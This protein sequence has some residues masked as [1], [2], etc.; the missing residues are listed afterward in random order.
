[1]GLWCLNKHSHPLM[2]KAI[3]QVWREVV[4][5]RIWPVMRVPMFI[6][7]RTNA[8]SH[9]LWRHCNEFFCLIL[10]FLFSYHV[11]I[12]FSDE[13]NAA[14]LMMINQWTRLR[15]GA[16]RKQAIT[17]AYVD[18]DICR[19]LAMIII[20]MFYRIF[21]QRYSKWPQC[22][23]MCFSERI[24]IAT[25]DL[26]FTEFGSQNSNRQC[27]SIDSRYGL[28]PKR[29]RVII[30][31]NVY[32]VLWYHYASHSLMWG[33]S[34]L[35]CDTIWR[36]WTGSLLHD[37]V[38]KW[39]NFP[40]YWPFVRGIYRSLV[41]SLHKGQWRGALMF[42]L[43]CVWIKGWLNNRE[44]GDLRRHRAHYDVILMVQVMSCRLLGTIKAII[45][46]N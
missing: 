29:H 37:D 30:W 32:I 44:A 12:M 19:H 10:W 22:T 35:P 36:R 42:S 3:G 45:W 13:Y 7:L 9:P 18:P 34:S 21:S 38:I 41:N 28:A 17:W 33:N 24:Y 26:N 5:C 4:G 2:S 1:M 46:T 43:I 8:L 25:L 14:L 27:I 15:L 39:K 11:M 20:L 40:R 16:I 23:K 6:G 31:T